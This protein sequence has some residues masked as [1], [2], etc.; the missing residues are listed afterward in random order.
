MRAG[1]SF[2]GA[3]SVVVDDAAEPSR[4][5]FRRVVADEQLGVSL[6]DA[7]RAVGR[8]M[9]NPDLEQVALVAALQRRTGGSMAEVLERVTGTIRERFELRRLVQTLTAQGRL[10][11]WI[12]SALPVVLLVAISIISP[13][14]SDPLFTTTGGRIALLF[15]AVMVVL[16]SYV[17]KRIVDIKV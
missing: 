14:Y 9:D 8:R 17:I 4:T 1:H 11:R 12:V 2:V 10:S 7:I 3:L 16:G 6:E 15:S 13:G 5:E